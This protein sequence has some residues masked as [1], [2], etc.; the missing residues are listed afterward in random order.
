MTVA[1]NVFQYSAPCTGPQPMAAT[2]RRSG[3]GQRDEAR[4]VV[5]LGTCA[6]AAVVDAKQMAVRVDQGSRAQVQSCAGCWGIRV[7]VQKAVAERQTRVRIIK[8]TRTQLCAVCHEQ[9]TR[10]GSENNNHGVSQL[11]AHNQCVST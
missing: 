10:K 2:C 4:A 7:Q 11:E 8:H 3:R 9:R 5:P 6:S 1:G